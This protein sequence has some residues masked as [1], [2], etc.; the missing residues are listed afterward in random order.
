MGCQGSFQSGT[1]QL[2]FGLLHFLAYHEF[3]TSSSRFQIWGIIKQI[4]SSKYNSHFCR[5][6]I[7]SGNLLHLPMGYL[8]CVHSTSVCQ[9]HSV[10]RRR[11]NFL[12]LLSV[13]F[14]TFNFRPVCLVEI[15]LNR[16]VAFCRALYCQRQI[17]IAFFPLDF[18]I[19]S[20][21]S[22]LSTRA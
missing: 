13:Y 4:P 12:T 19:P 6:A 2:F 18:L 20:T 9:S 14:Y 3:R 22:F 5:V 16:K 1:E 21:R 17:R 11:I 7:E 10:I 8:S 15:Q